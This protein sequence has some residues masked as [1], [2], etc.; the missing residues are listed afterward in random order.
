VSSQFFFLL[1][2]VQNVICRYNLLILAENIANWIG[3][4]EDFDKVLC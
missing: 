4:T 3:N 1:I 2:I